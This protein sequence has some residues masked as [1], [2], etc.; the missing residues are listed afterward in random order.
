MRACRAERWAA[1][2]IGAAL[3]WALPAAAQRDAPIELVPP[4]GALPSTSTMPALLPAPLPAPSAPPPASALPAEPP[5]AP[6]PTGGG[7]NAIQVAPLQPIDTSW[8]GTLDPSKGGFPNDMW[9]GTRQSF[10]GMA[11]PLLQPNSAPA[12][13]DLARRLL[14]S[15]AQAPTAVGDVAATPGLLALR[16]DRLYALGLVADTLALLN[17]ISASATVEI[18]E[19]DRIEL[20]F[21]ANDIS[22]ACR[23]L[24]ER[25]AQYQGVW[26]DKAM[27]ACAALTGD[28]AKASLGMSILADEKAP[29]DLAFDAMILKMAGRPLKKP[30]KPAPFTDPTPMRLALLA[31]AKMPLPPD[32]LAAAGPAALLGYATNTAVPP[33][34]RLPAAER[35]AQLGALPAR[36]LG[37]LYGQIEFKPAERDAVKKA[38]KPP[39]NSRQRALLY[40]F[41]NLATEPAARMAAI[42]ALMADA[43]KRGAFMATARLLAPAL[44]ELPFTD[45]DKDFAGIAARILLAVG[46]GDA[47][48]PW[49]VASQDKAALVLS[50]LALPG[51]PRVDATL[52]RDALAGISA[53][54]GA[55]AAH[56]A[57]LLYSVL[58][59]LGADPGA[60]AALALGVPPRQGALPNAALWDAQQRAVQDKRL[61]ETVLTT[62]LICQN[63]AALTQEPIVLARAVA[64]L[65]SVGLAAEAHALALEAALEAGI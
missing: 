65:V 19:R 44:D 35:A 27:V 59:A 51:V 29:P 50:R 10:V 11:L 37:D 62:I 33:E 9:D 41:A 49:V 13:D 12:L 5:G 6:P 22:G 20:R 54:D 16:I 14:L 61:G 58:T 4:P 64:G 18:I 63:D 26:W 1:L 28:F 2:L 53:A 39:A 48:Q 47:A 21:A 55:T 43:R 42:T 57:D 45:T 3:L 17:R 52:A 34:Q 7:D 25:I 38:L 40:S 60:L 23:D 56:R 24:E 31:A 32:A 36:A 8:T 15:D 30:V 46:H